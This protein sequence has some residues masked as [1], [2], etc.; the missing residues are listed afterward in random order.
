MAV[1]NL[2]Q[3]NFFKRTPLTLLFLPESPVSITLSVILIV[4]QLIKKQNSMY[5]ALRNRTNF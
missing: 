5:S 4:T 1:W 2:I 3:R